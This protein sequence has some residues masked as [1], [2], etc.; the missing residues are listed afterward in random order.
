MTSSVE[1]MATKSEHE[2]SFSEL[3][4]EV[5]AADQLQVKQIKKKIDLRICVVLGVMYTASLVDRVNLPV[6][7]SF[8]GSFKKNTD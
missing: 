6:S 1:D 5:D 7:V 4:E 8:S 3:G 2:E